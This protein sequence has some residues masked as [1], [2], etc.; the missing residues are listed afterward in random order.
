MDAPSDDGVK[1][2]SSPLGFVNEN[3]SEYKSLERKTLYKLD[4]VLVTTMAILY[5][6]AFL[7]RSNIDRKSV[8]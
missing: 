5:L 4:F 6:L 7:D 3:S 1:D 8:V 2:V